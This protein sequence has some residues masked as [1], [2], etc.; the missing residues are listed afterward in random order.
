MAAT[1]Q[2]DTLS[3]VAGS[4]F[5]TGWDYKGE[6]VTSLA[7]DG[8]ERFS[9]YS[10]S[11]DSTLLFAGPARFSGLSGNAA[12]LIPIG[13]ADNINFQSDAGL[14][15]LYEVGSNRSF[16]TRGKTTNAFSISKLLADQQSL[17]YALSQNAYRPALADAG[18][19]A[20]GATTPNSNIQMN[21]DS[22]YFNVPFGLLVV[23][24]TKG[25]GLDGYGKVL[26]A[27]YL[28]YVVLQSYNFGVI[29]TQP[30]ISENVSAQY[31][32]LVPVNFS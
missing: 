8:L 7:E 1:P 24:K 2:N 5:S 32:R 13:L 27:S 30:V 18:V 12:S 25:G 26:T 16:F 9:Q 17:L 15:R 3:T 20:A 14:A 21:L 22:E 19:E 31:D 29:S 11:P 4:G 28:E 6:Y 10:A 23:F